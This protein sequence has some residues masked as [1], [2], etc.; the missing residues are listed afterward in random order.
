M[1]KDNSLRGKD[2]PFVK[3]IFKKDLNQIPPPKDLD[4]FLDRLKKVTETG[5]K[6]VDVLNDISNAKDT[7]EAQDVLDD[8]EVKP[9]GT[10]AGH[11]IVPE[12]Y[13]GRKVKV[14]IKKL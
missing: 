10:Y 13:V 6:V 2:N 12:K 5:V 3:P 1:A 8:K 9:F 4:E 11:I 7:I 14:I